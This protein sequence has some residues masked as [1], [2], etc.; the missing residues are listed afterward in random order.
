VIVAEGDAER[1]EQL[2]R[3]EGQSVHRI[4]RIEARRAGEARAQ[5]VG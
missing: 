5:V 1:A 3:A 4:G 2:L